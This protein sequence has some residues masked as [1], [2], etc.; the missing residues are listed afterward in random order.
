VFVEV[1]PTVD[2]PL[3]FDELMPLV[4]GGVFTRLYFHILEGRTRELPELLEELTY[5]ALLPFVGPEAAATQ[6]RGSR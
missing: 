3:S 5:F 4:I 1:E 6:Y 2:S